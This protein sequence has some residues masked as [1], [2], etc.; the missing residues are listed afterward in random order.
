MKKRKYRFYAVLVML[1]MLISLSGCS[2]QTMNRQIAES[3]GTLG[4]YE[5]DE[6][7]ETPKMRAQR[8]IEEAKAEV[9]ED[10]SGYLERAAR[11]AA[12]Y[13]YTKALAELA[14]IDESYQDDDRVITAKI[15]YQRLQNLMVPYNDEIPHL[16]VKSLVVDPALAFDGDD[17]SYYYNNWMLTVDEFKK[18]LQAL[19][20]NN[21]VM[22]DIRDVV[23]DIENEDGTTSFAVNMPE[24]P[25]DKKPFIFSFT[26]A[27]YY[28]HTDGNGFSDAM[29]LDEN[30]MVKN[31]YTDASGET[32]IGAYDVVP[33]VDEFVEEHPDFSLRSAKGII[34][35]T[36]YEGVF[37]YGIET[38]GS[39]IAEIAD[40]LT[41][42]GWQ[43]ACQGFDNVSLENGMT[44]DEMVADIEE[45]DEKVG[46]LVGDTDILV[47]PYGEAVS[48]ETMKME[49]LLEHGFQY[50][51]GLWNTAEF[52]EVK[53]DYMYQT[54]RNLDGYDLYFW[55]EYFT[56]F[57]DVDAILD[58]TRPAFE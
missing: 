15:E 9:E 27:N 40:S 49:Y 58:T 56:D 14:K 21:Y 17:M 8:E 53:P 13:D 20:D 41:A 32:L 7:V 18:I 46:S 55:K 57:F 3:I 52:V 2:R 28:A 19:Y 37:G 5:N 33:I 23:V 38:G 47:Y 26:E 45:W 24:V 48:A 43:I 50:M 29:V 11:L 1:A 4:K 12:S 42:N 35:L 6:P 31:R 51:L 34:S 54:R 36:G 22:M 25:K 10:V 30:G 16:S 44:Y 39:T